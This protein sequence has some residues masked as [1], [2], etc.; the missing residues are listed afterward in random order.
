MESGVVETFL[1]ERAGVGGDGISAPALLHRG[2][3]QLAAESSLRAPELLEESRTR[4]ICFSILGINL[5]LHRAR[6]CYLDFWAN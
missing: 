3:E 4:K 5:C 6:L 1:R 2:E